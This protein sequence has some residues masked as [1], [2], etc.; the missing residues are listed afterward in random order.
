M[1]ATKDPSADD[2]AARGPGSGLVREVAAVAAQAAIVRDAVAD[3]ARECG[4]PDELTA[5]LVLASYEAMA[6][7]VEHAYPDDEHGTMTIIASRE[8]DVVEVTVTDTGHWQ[9]A[10]SRPHGGHGLRMIR[11]LAP[12]T[13]IATSP[14]G[15]TVRM[16][17]PSMGPADTPDQ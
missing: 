2:P 11:A 1:D 4:L 15:T 17:W 14:T 7:V 8:P 13:S 5:D 16:T 10:D 3:W 12:D 9:E 6:N